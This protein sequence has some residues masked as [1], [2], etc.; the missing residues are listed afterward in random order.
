MNNVFTATFRFTGSLN[1]FLRHNKKNNRFDITFNGNPGIKD[2][3]ESLGIPHPEVRLISVNQVPV[4]YSY[5]LQ[6]GDI[7]EVFPFQTGPV[8]PEA[9]KPSFVLDVHLGKLARLLRMMGFDS[10]YSND[11]SDRELVIIATEQ[12]R[13]LLTRDIGVLKYCI[14]QFGHWLRSTNPL[15]QAKE[16]TGYYNLCS[17]VAPLS[18]CIECNSPLV[19]VQKSEVQNLLQP[20]TIHFYDDFT[21]CVHCG[22]VYW[23][24]THVQQ[25]NRTLEQICPHLK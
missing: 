17:I 7:V 18:L 4:D 23:H 21:Q 6:S 2:T 11:Y 20:G 5:H 9:E 22:K 24:G 16:I 10:L 19:K 8:P 3:I 13:I 25:I 15:V 12:K 14:L 1:D